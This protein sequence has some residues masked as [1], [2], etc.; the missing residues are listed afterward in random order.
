MVNR[1]D[2]ENDAESSAPSD[3][4][5]EIEE[6]PER[7]RSRKIGR[8]TIIKTPI[9]GVKRSKKI[10]D[11]QSPDSVSDCL[12]FQAALIEAGSCINIPTEESEYISP[13]EQ[14]RRILQVYKNKFRVRRIRSDSGASATMYGRIMKSN[15]SRRRL[16]FIANSGTG[17]P[18]LPKEIADEHDLEIR[19]VDPDEP[20]CG[21]VRP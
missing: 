8:K 15:T 5:A 21:C 6:E 19:D 11:E 7:T 3:S 18:I 16:C 10:S 13:E 9:R 2:T 17:I 14:S 1:P 20:G 12:D 4:E